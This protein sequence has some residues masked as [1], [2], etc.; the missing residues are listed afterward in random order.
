L[1]FSSETLK[2]TFAPVS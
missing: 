2:S 1:T